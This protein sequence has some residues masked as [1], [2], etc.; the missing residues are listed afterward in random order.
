MSELEPDLPAQVHDAPVGRI[1]V[2]RHNVGCLLLPSSR[3]ARSTSVLGARALAWRVGLE[4]TARDRR[5]PRRAAERYLPRVTAACLH[6]RPHQPAGVPGA[7]RPG[8]ELRARRR[9]RALR[10][11]PDDG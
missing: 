5:G 9:G 10:H 6:H 2:I 7:P 8:L 1:A 3:G 4:G 11:H